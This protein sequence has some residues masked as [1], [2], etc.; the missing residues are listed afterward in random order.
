MNESE[1]IENYDNDEETNIMFNENEDIVNMY[2]NIIDEQINHCNINEEYSIKLIIKDRVEI[3]KLKKENR[4]NRFIYTYTIPYTNVKLIYIPNLLLNNELNE[5]L[6]EKQ[7]QT[8]HQ[9]VNSGFSYDGIRY[10]M[11][12]LERN[13]SFE[14]ANKLLTEAYVSNYGSVNAGKKNCKI[15]DK[16][17]KLNNKCL[18]NLYTK[19]HNINNEYALNHIEELLYMY[20]FI[21]YNI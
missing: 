19:I 18:F 3:I 9:G 4:N 5:L 7:N 20:V 2:H 11:N 10:P 16:V 15:L 13:W 6:T 17:N 12:H 14:T 8:W 1:E 21:I